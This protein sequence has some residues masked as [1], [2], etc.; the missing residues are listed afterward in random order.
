MELAHGDIIYLSPLFI[1]PGSDYERKAAE[2]NIRPLDDAEIKRQ[3][4]L[5]KGGLRFPTDES[6]PKISTYDVREFIY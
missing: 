4:Q 3:M 1:H 6:L 2:C 5:I